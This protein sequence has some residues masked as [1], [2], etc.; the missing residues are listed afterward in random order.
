MRKCCYCGKTE[1]EEDL[2]PYGPN[3]QDICFDC[4][5]STPERELEAE[6]NF[7]TLLNSHTGPILL[8]DTGPEPLCLK[9]N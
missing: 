4:M 5:K 9:D 3:F 1:K 6:K 2:R 8:S 7:K